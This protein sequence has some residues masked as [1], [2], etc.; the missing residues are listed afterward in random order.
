MSPDMLAPC[1]GLHLRLWDG[2]V[3]LSSAFAQGPQLLDCDWLQLLRLL[4]LL[5][6]PAMID[7]ITLNCELKRSPSLSSFYQGI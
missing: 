4:P 3:G 7:R 6:T 1:P 5:P 2:E